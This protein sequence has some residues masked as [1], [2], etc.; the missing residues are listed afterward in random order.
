MTNLMEGGFGNAMEH[1]Q[2]GFS[3]PLQ[4]YAS[5]EY[6]SAVKQP[7]EPTWLYTY[8]GPAVNT[9]LYGV[10]GYGVVFDDY[11]NGIFA[12]DEVLDNDEASDWSGTY[13]LADEEDLL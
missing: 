13:D 6:S 3:G 4:E 9:D 1:P 5:M 8:E 7:D 11:Y 12:V 2:H 10:N